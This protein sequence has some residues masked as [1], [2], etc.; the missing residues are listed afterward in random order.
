MASVQ[1]MLAI[2]IIIAQFIFLNCCSG[3]I[4]NLQA[5]PHRNCPSFIARLLVPFQFTSSSLLSQSLNLLWSVRATLM[6]QLAIYTTERSSTP[7]PE[8][9]IAS[10][11]H[12]RTPSHLA[13]SSFLPL[14][15]S[16]LSPSIRSSLTISGS[17]YGDTVV[18]T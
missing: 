8:L 9:H 1:Y 15:S 3:Y 11:L 16:C 13:F 12:P 18:H 6:T 5:A 2:I 4:A 10:S 17:E 7:T 14:P